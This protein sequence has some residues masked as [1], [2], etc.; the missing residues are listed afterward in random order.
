MALL[1]RNKKQ[2]NPYSFSTGINYTPIP[3]V[4]FGV[5][6]RI[7]AG[8]YSSG[9]LTMDLSYR[10]GEPWSSQ[11]SPD[12][13]NFKRTLAGSRLDLVERNNSIVLDYQQQTL[14]N[15]TLPSHLTGQEGQSLVLN[16]QVNS[17]YGLDKLLWNAS[18]LL[19]AGGELVTSVLTSITI[20]L[21]AYTTNT[22]NIYPI[23]AIAYDRHGNASEQVISQVTVESESTAEPEVTENIPVV[24]N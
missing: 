21:P 8:G 24:V 16:A 9:Q 20:K 15:L 4:T 5:S 12:S 3:L 10:F 19:A 13:V 23:T 22:Y 11:I 2:K 14:I 18:T 17:K 6:Q 7:G 1:D